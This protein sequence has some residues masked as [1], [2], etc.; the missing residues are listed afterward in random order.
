[1]ATT[2]KRAKKTRG[3]AKRAS[4]GTKASARHIVELDGPR[5]KKVF[6]EID[7]V[8][9]QNG[10]RAK[11]AELQLLPSKSQPKPAATRRA[12]PAALAMSA[13]AVI[14]SDLDCPPPKRWRR[15]CFIDDNGNIRCED[16]CV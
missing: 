14:F 1:M 10:F 3:T 9:R 8:L 13:P 4:T 11:L 12:A 2:K 16:R 6:R 15:V 5:A 7:G